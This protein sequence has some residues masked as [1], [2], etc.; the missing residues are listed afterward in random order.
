MLDFIIMWLFIPF[1]FLLVVVLA[2]EKDGIL[3]PSVIGFVVVGLLYMA[4]AYPGWRW[5]WDHP[6]LTIMYGLAYFGFGVLWSILKWYF[7]CR[8]KAQDYKRRAP[9]LTLEYEELKKKSSFVDV[10]YAKWLQSNYDYPPKFDYYMMM[11]LRFWIVCWPV[12][13]IDFFFSEFLNRILNWTIDRLKGV[14]TGIAKRVFN[15]E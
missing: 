10:T 2:D 13:F 12:S 1:C 4:A 11:K 15:I 6:Q 5:F 8:D 14:Y 9:S 7:L 3:Q